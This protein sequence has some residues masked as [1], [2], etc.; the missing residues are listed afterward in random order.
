MRQR[1]ERLAPVQHTHRQDTLPGLGKTIAS[2]ANRDGIAERC[3][4]P[5]VQQSLAGDLA[6]IG[7]DDPLLNDVEFSIVHTAKQHDPQT[8]AR[9]Q[10][11]PG[12][13]TILRLVLLYD[14]HTMDRL[15]RVQD[16]VSSCRLVTCAKESAGTRSGTSGATIG[17]A[18]LQWA[19]SEAAVLFLRTN[20]TGQK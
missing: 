18:S 2:K 8:F 9:R 1:A 3:P 13:G 11:V 4:D 15:P 6:R 12:I 7:H 17:T 5:A 19:F 14:I 16:F 10:S 20:P